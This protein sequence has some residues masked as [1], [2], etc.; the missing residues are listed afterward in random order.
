MDDL[1][2]TGSTIGECVR[3]LRARGA[4][5]VRVYTL[6]R[7]VPPWRR[8]A[9]DAREALEATDRLNH[10][11]VETATQKYAFVS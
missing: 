8:P 6:A 3:A 1:F 10:A 9:A 11:G 5:E 4:A 7:P 2:T